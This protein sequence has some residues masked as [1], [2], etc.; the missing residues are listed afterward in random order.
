MSTWKN[1]VKTKLHEYHSS[2]AKIQI[3][4]YHHS[5]GRW[6][7]FCFLLRMYPSYSKKRC[8]LKAI[9]A[10]NQ[11]LTRRP[12]TSIN[13]QHV[14][15]FLPAQSHNEERAFL[16]HKVNQNHRVYVFDINQQGIT[17]RAA[18]IA[19]NESAAQGIRREAKLLAKLSDRLNFYT[20]DVLW[21]ESWKGGC[22]LQVSALPSHFSRHPK[23]RAVPTN[24]LD[25]IANL[26]PKNLPKTLP[27]ENIPNVQGARERSSSELFNSVLKGVDKSVELMVVAAHRDLGSENIFSSADAS[28]P[29]HFAL[30]DWE[31]FTDTA[32]ALTDQVGIW[33]GTHHRVL[34][35][36]GI[37]EIRKLQ[38]AFLSDFSGFPEGKVGA[39]IAL[40]HL[41]ELGIDLA[42][43]LIE[44]RSHEKDSM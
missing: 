5:G 21:F 37:T 17:L 30:I 20:P 11:L 23:G 29:S 34:K 42:D 18:K 26:R 31:F 19:L 27:L 3:I 22:V 25:E 2:V 12:P 13:P 10:L 9:N 6:Q 44:S 33:L 15:K 24:L 36:G 7:S 43:I 32:P 16:C 41:A 28:A 40:F 8:I 39:V 38:V 14:S 1:S 4:D 35:G